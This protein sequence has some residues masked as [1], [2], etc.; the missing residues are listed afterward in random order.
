LNRFDDIVVFDALTTTEL[1]EIVD[2]QLA[3][4]EPP[5]R[6]PAANWWEHVRGKEC[7]R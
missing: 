5:A 4:L 2:I 1:T 6:D 7:W 3:S